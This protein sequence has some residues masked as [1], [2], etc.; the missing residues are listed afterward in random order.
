MALQSVR[1]RLSLLIYLI[2]GILFLVVGITIARNHAIYNSSYYVMLAAGALIL[3]AAASISNCKI[4]PWL[5][6]AFIAALFLLMVALHRYCVVELQAEYIQGDAAEVINN[7]R[8]LALTGHYVDPSPDGNAYFAQFQNQFGMLIL[9]RLFFQ[10]TQA[11]FHTTD[12][13]CLFILNQFAMDFSILLTILLAEKLGREHHE[14]N[15]GLL[16]AV[17]CLFAPFL[18]LYVTAL[19]TDVLCMPFIMG[20]ILL[21]MRIYGKLRQREESGAIAKAGE[22][23]DFL[24]V[25]ALG[26]LIGIGYKIKGNLIILLIAV[27]IASFFQLSP[28]KWFKSCA[29]LALAFACVLLAT[30]LYLK[31]TGMLTGETSDRYKFPTTHW[32]MMSMDGYGYNAEDVQYTYSFPTYAEK[33]EAVAARMKE[34]AEAMGVSGLLHQALLK[35][36]QTGWNNGTFG[37]AL[38][39]GDVPDRIRPVHSSWMH[40]YIVGAGKYYSSYFR[41]ANVCWL[42]LLLP[43]ALTLLMFRRRMSFGLMTSQLFLVG[44]LLFFMLW[45][46]TNRYIFSSSPLVLVL[47]ALQWKSLARI[48]GHLLACR[49]CPF[50]QLPCF[51]NYEQMIR[52]EVACGEEKLAGFHL[53]LYA[54][55]VK[56]LNEKNYRLFRERL[57]LLRGELDVIAAHRELNEKISFFLETWKDMDRC[58]AAEL[59]CARVTGQRL[60]DS[61][62]AQNLLSGAADQL[63]EWMRRAEAQAGGKD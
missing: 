22:W 46:S 12:D 3:G 45:E 24:S 62:G 5:Y 33:K 15:V 14:R 44:T 36:T 19:Y 56:M 1:K 23:K 17:L 32:I 61:A 25:F 58:N 51:L 13:S 4:P 39:H 63:R 49:H 55:F 57:G 11:V 53:K 9:Y 40:E 38:F 60:L 41:F 34:K 42:L 10:F 26:F 29:A 31:A 18:S 21:S 50:A 30:N 2:G 8:S 43:M 28:K 37:V 35:A 52:D 48:P 54:G 59:H 20:G 6:C 47:A 16:A 7:A 27:V